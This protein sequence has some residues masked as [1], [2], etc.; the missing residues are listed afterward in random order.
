MP[1]GPWALT[2]HG[3]RAEMK[4]KNNPYD[5]DSWAVLLREA[6][7]C[8]INRLTLFCSCNETD[9]I[10][11]VIIQSTAPDRSRMLYEQLVTQFPTSA[12]YWRV[13]IEQEVFLEAVV[14]LCFTLLVQLSVSGLGLVGVVLIFNPFLT[15]TSIGMMKPVNLVKSTQTKLKFSQKY[16]NNFKKVCNTVT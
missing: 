6:Q 7:V 9:I 10:H 4:I 16:T 5:L 15:C 8:C 1:S 3:K 14:N 12:R 2:D 11:C 13:Y